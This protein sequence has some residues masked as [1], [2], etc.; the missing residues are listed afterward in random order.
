[1]TVTPTDPSQE[2]AVDTAEA[3]TSATEAVAEGSADQADFGTDEDLGIPEDIPT[4]DDPS[5]RATSRD[6]D[7]AGFTL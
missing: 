5:S 4:A 3:V 7:S 6:M 1:M 2:S